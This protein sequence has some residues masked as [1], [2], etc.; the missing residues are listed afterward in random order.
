MATPFWGVAGAA[1]IAKTQTVELDQTSGTYF[2]TTT[3]WCRES[4]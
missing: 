4:L 1:A 3:T 2:R